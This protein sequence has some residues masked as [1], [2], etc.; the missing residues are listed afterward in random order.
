MTTNRYIVIEEEENPE[1]KS[2]RESYSDPFPIKLP[3]MYEPR[4]TVRR[5]EG[6]IDWECNRVGSIE[7]TPISHSRCSY[8][9]YRHAVV[10]EEATDMAM[11]IC[12]ERKE[13]EEKCCDK[14]EQC[15]DD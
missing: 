15:E 11:E 9:R 14:H 13:S 10:R 1:R 8:Q 4:P 2:E 7:T 3:E 12:R 5:L 6:L